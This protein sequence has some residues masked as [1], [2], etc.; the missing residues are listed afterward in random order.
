MMA[1][2]EII[3]SM[4]RRKN[5]YSWVANKLDLEKAYDTFRGSFIGKTLK[6]KVNYE[7]H[8]WI[9]LI[10]SCI[11]SSSLSILFNGDVTNSFNPMDE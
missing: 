3:N 11:T 4:K 5:K 1:V 6:D 8:N 2:E 9:R 7:L 10:M